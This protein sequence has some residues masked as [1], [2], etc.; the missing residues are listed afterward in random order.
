MPE[1]RNP[2]PPRKPKRLEIP[3]LAEFMAKLEQRT[4]PLKLTVLGQSRTWGRP[5]LKECYEFEIRPQR[6]LRL[7]TDV[8]EGG[9]EPDPVYTE[10]DAFVR[11]RE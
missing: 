10:Y 9:E 7:I 4:E 8:L 1:R 2:P 11:E 5:D 6:L 3:T